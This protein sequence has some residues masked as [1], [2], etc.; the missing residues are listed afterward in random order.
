M[1]LKVNV[2][3]YLYDFNPQIFKVLTGETVV[4]ISIQVPKSQHRV[5]RKPFI[6]SDSIDLFTDEFYYVQVA[7]K[8]FQ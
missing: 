7:N 1:Q 3:S 6:R 2:F 4:S 8:V 5:L